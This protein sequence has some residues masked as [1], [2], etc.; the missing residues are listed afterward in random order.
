[1]SNVVTRRERW[2]LRGGSS[3]SLCERQDFLTKL[4]SP[5]VRTQEWCQSAL[6]FLVDLQYWAPVENWDSTGPVRLNFTGLGNAHWTL[7]AAAA[8]YTA[9]LTHIT[10]TSRTLYS[11]RILRTT[12]ESQLGSDA[13][14]GLRPLHP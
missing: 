7:E 8:D 9:H 1:M 4:G 13:D 2:V 12:T 3:T 14:P 11:V 10:A 5:T 6:Q